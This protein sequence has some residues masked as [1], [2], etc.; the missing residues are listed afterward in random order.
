MITYLTTTSHKIIKHIFYILG[1]ILALSVCMPVITVG[2][3]VG[4]SPSF[5]Y[6]VTN[7]K[8]SNEPTD[9]GN[10]VKTETVNPTTSILKRLTDFF[11]LTGAPYDTSTSK[12]TNYIKWILNILLSL[13]SLISLV[14]IIF[15]FYLIFFSKGEEGVTK[16]KKI[17]IGVAIAL[18]VM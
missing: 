9:I 16:A 2:Q 14:M 15:A 12:A 17:F 8:G 13:V 10:I 4:S 18:A 11:K 6:N 7:L 5:Y 3:N 1:G